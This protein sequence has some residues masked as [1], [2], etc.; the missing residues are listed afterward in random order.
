[1]K[2]ALYYP[3]VYLKSGVERTIYQTITRSRHEWDIFTSHYDKNNTF[4][5]FK[6]LNINILSSISV[7]RSFYHTIRAILKISIMKINEEKYDAILIHSEGL[8]NFFTLKH[9][10]IPIFCYCH[11]PVRSVYDPVYIDTY[12]KNNPNKKYLLKIFSIIYRYFD[13]KCWNRYDKVFVNSLEVKKRLLDNNLVDKNKI[14]VLNPGID[15]S[16]SDFSLINEKYFLVAG[17]IMWTKNIELAINAFNDFSYSTGTYKLIIAGMVDKKSENYLLQLMKL[18]D[19]NRNIIFKISPTDSELTN[20]YKKCTALLF[21]PLNEDFGMV[22]LEAMSFG[23]PVIAV[24][25]GG[26][27]E[28]IVNNKTGYLVEPFPG[29][30]SIKMKMLVENKTI[31]NS[32]AK[33]SYNHIKKYDWSNYVTKI[34]NYIDT[35]KN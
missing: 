14:I 11:T 3:W 25:N 18:T 1:L 34:D 30:F 27:K 2:I 23:K 21:P 16:I 6:N 28:T 26:P 22:P 12:L 24:K 5:E 15:V 32:M 9:N 4:P 33:A 19:N 13:K 10:K 7:N 29:K 20:L 35:L 8:G 31:Y 17:R